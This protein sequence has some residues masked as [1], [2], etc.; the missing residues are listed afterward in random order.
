MINKLLWRTILGNLNLA[1]LLT[2]VNW[3]LLLRV[4]LRSTLRKILLW[5]IGVLVCRNFDGHMPSGDADACRLWLLIT[6]LL[7]FS[8]LLLLLNYL[9]RKRLSAFFLNSRNGLWVASVCT[10]L[11]TLVWELSVFRSSITLVLLSACNALI[12]IGISYIPSSRLSRIALALP[13][14]FGWIMGLVKRA[15]YMPIVVLPILGLILYSFSLREHAPI[16][17]LASN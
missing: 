16:E 12:V 11:L 5:P 10:F 6:A 17:T 14:W 13:F 15:D 1:A 3:A 7:K 8:L 2:W 4:P 9:S